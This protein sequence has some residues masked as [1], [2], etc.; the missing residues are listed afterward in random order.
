MNFLRKYINVYVFLASLLLGILAVYVTNGDER[1]IYVYPTDETAE[2]LIYRDK[3][4]NCFQFEKEEV[5]CPDD[6]AHIFSFPAQS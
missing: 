1:V 6:P 2:N 5:A 4:D 3:T